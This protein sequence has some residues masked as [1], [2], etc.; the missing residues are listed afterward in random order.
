VNDSR[1][2]VIGVLLF[3]LLNV[4]LYSAENNLSQHR[5]FW[6]DILIYLDVIKFIVYQYCY[7][8]I[9]FINFEFIYFIKYDMRSIYRRI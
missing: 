9:N 1:F 8:V 5:M 4:S 7:G 3:F 2:M 6:K